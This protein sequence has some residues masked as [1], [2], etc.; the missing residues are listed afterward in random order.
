[1]VIGTTT[2]IVV[3]QIKVS[4]WQTWNHNTGVALAI[5]S[6]MHTFFLLVSYT[7]T[8]SWTHD[9]TLHLELIR[10]GFASSAT[11]HWQVRHAYIISQNT[12][13]A[14]MAVQLEGL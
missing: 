4:T 6:D 11:A 1:L 8:G 3:G 12:K 2:K 14:N 5:K 7:P 10:R 9:L 13:K